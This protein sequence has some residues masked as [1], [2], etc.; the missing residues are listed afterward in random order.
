MNIHVAGPE[1]KTMNE[2][3]QSHSS[4]YF[5]AI[6]MVNFYKSERKMAKIYS[7]TSTNGN[8]KAQKFLRQF[9]VNSVIDARIE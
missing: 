7:I 6:E 9:C 8:R 5:S 1:Q 3:I 4:D 2:Y